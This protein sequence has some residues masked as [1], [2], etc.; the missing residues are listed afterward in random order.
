MSFRDYRDREGGGGGRGAPRAT[1]SLLASQPAAETYDAVREVEAIPVVRYA[2]AAAAPRRE[3]QTFNADMIGTTVDERV[4]CGLMNHPVAQAKRCGELSLVLDGKVTEA[5]LG[6]VTTA[7][8]RGYVAVQAFNFFSKSDL[9]DPNLLKLVS[10]V[11][12]TV[13]SVRFG[14]NFNPQANKQAG[15]II[16]STKVPLSWLLDFFISHPSLEHLWVKQANNAEHTVSGDFLRSLL[17]ASGN[18]DVSV[19]TKQD[20]LITGYIA[21]APTDDGFFDTLLEILGRDL[22]EATSVSHSISDLRSFVDVDET[23]LQRLAKVTCLTHALHIQFALK[24]HLEEHKAIGSYASKRKPSSEETALLTIRERFVGLEQP[25]TIG[26]FNQ[27]LRTTL[28]EMPEDRRSRGLL[29]KIGGVYEELR[30]LIADYCELVAELTTACL[31]ADPHE[32]KATADP[33]SLAQLMFPLA[34][35][36]LA[37]TADIGRYTQ[38]DVVLHDVEDYINGRDYSYDKA[39]HLRGL[40][41]AHAELETLSAILSRKPICGLNFEQPEVVLGSMDEDCSVEVLTGMLSAIAES[42]PSIA[43]LSLTLPGCRLPF[44]QLIRFIV[45]C[46]QLDELRYSMGT[47]SGFILNKQQIDQLR[48]RFHSVSELEVDASLAASINRLGEHLRE[49]QADETSL[50]KMALADCNLFAGSEHDN[51]IRQLASVIGCADGAGTLLTKIIAFSCSPDLQSKVRMTLNSFVRLG[52]TS[53]HDGDTVQRF[54]RRL[55]QII[56][57]AEFYSGY[58]ELLGVLGYESTTQQ[59]RFPHM[60][61][62]LSRLIDLHAGVEVR[63]LARAQLGWDAID[64]PVHGSGRGGVVKDSPLADVSYTSVED[65]PE[66]TP[67]TCC[68]CLFGGRRRDPADADYHQMTDAADGRGDTSTSGMSRNS[69]GRRW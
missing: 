11:S 36:A 21:G 43:E 23:G 26:A 8:T 52:S 66:P 49:E 51:Q 13:R 67:R 32:G 69:S 4:L 19:S 22:S 7:L 62:K 47:G 3:V 18:H 2:G 29:D 20:D 45:S 24:K 30:S 14:V 53:T 46:Q 42:S 16:P 64:G 33:I 59:T 25:L 6:T 34:P 39:I 58:T 61:S 27:A 57:F 17:V 65:D 54:N 10:Y 9:A 40:H 56:P 63:F 28:E 50:L 12:A 1:T 15:S 68:D 35:G 5:P 60:R 38:A 48:E 41:F 31:V 55:Y 37:D 44:D